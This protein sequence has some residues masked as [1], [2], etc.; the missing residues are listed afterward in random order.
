MSLIALGTRVAYHHRAAVARYRTKHRGRWELTEGIRKGEAGLT[1]GEPFV[2]LAVG[3]ADY[4]RPPGFAARGGINKTVMVWPEEG[5]AV[6]VGLVRRGRG[7]SH[8]PSG[9]ANPYGDDDWEPGWFEAESYFDLY[10]LR[11][12][13]KGI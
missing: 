13:L 10:A 2:Y 3:F 5:S 9:G 8:A 4:R 1:E 12:E 11:H 6:V 7:E